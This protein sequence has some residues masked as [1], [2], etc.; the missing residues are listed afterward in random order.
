MCE[1]VRHALRTV[2]EHSG[3][4]DPTEGEQETGQS[5]GGIG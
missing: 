2:L 4:D 3:A 1:R 5:V